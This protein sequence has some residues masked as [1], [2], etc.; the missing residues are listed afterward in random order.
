MG[1]PRRTRVREMAEP[2]TA[3]YCSDS[4]P[5]PHPLEQGKDSWR[6]LLTHRPVVQHLERYDRTV[7]RNDAIHDDTR[8]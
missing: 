5:R 7:G 4:R 6:A 2:G 8:L 1:S 3:W